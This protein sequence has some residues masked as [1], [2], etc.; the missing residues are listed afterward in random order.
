L[1]PDNGV[2]LV[3]EVE[4]EGHAGKDA[5][6]VRTDEN[7]DAVWEQTFSGLGDD[8][9]Y[10]CAL[11][12]NA[13]VVICGKWG[14]ETPL[15]WVARINLDGSIVWSRN[16]YVEENEIG[17]YREIIKT[18]NYLYCVGHWTPDPYDELDY[19]HYRTQMHLTGDLF[20]NRYDFSPMEFGVSLVVVEQDEIY[21]VVQSDNPAVVGE[22]GPRCSI[23]RYNEYLGFLPQFDGFSVFGSKVHAKKMIR[24]LD[25]PGRYALV[26]FTEDPG[27]SIGGASVFLLKIDGSVSSLETV[28][29]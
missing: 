8:I 6:V 18:D 2:L 15:A 29:N 14:T 25:E 21:I 23:F 26:G 11:F 22:N 3:G 27:M 24:T 20:F 13:S 5:F 10:G 12:D 1:L 19:R 7:G 9:A 17:E 28:T 4:G 16:D